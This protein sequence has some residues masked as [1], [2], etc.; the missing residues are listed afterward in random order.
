MR[1]RDEPE[2]RTRCNHISPHR[3]PPPFDISWRPMLVEGT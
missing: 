2:H 1:Q 3:S